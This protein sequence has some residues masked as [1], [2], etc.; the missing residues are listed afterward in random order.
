MTK[1]PREGV[2]QRPREATKRRSDEATTHVDSFDCFAIVAPGLETLALAEAL[3]LG[4]PATIAAEG[5]GL[6]WRGDLRTVLLANVGLRIVSRVLVRVASFEARSFVE[7]E[8]QAR[9]IP[10][11]RMV[12]PDGAARF[13][14]TCR[15]SRLYHSDA[16]AQRLGDALVRALPGA[17]VE[18]A[19]GESAD[20]DSGGTGDEAQLFVVRLFHDRCT[21]SADTSGELLH[22]RGWRQATARAPLRETM[23][24]ALLA[25]SGWDGSAPLVD[26][27]CGSGT[28]VIEGALM[29]RGVPPG[30][31]RQFAVERWPGVPP[32]LGAWV[33]SELAGRGAVAAC[34][35]ISGSD[36][37]EGAIRAAASNAER[38]GV[39][40]DLTL[41]VHT[42]S[43]L[44]IPPGVRGWVVTNPPYGV[45]VG[46]ADR[47]RNLWARLG[48]VLRERA[49]GWQVALLSPDAALE[50]QLDIPLREVARTSNGGIPVR[51][52]VGQ[53]PP[54]D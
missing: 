44:E 30:A 45:R 20:E 13:R 41:A 25:A 3:R 22:R 31:K 1:R 39:R 48:Q 14:V 29:A 42:V 23:A 49:P 28:I 38:A 6:E 10:W 4:L 27:M 32:T 50:R 46:E 18:R 7:L 9:R 24:A 43:A 15:K 36:R 52:V 26:P 19:R 51:L 47:V 8:R 5:G 12:R 33:R 54:G 35:V 21:V 2:K 16:V 40:E 17:R 37:D 34:P 53:V 11:A